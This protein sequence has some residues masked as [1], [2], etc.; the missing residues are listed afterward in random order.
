MASYRLNESID[1]VDKVQVFSGSAGVTYGADNVMQWYIP[2]LY[3]QDG[4]GPARSWSEDIQLPGSSQIQNIRKVLT[5]RKAYPNLV[6]DPTVIIGDAGRDDNRTM[7]LRAEDNSALIIY[8]PTGA[9]VEIN[10]SCLGRPITASWFDPL[11]GSYTTSVNASA[12]NN[13]TA[14]FVPPTNSTHLDWV[15]VLEA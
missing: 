5:E 12:T 11:D 4:S 2:G 10:V 3:T 7:A 14:S 6:P 13:A 15:L 1:P 9:V 8:H